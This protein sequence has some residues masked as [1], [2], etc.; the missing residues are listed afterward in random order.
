MNMSRFVLSLEV[1][2]TYS[3]AFPSEETF[4]LTT[5]LF[6]KSVMYFNV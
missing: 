3:S 5:I 4:S 1:C 6:Y 2:S